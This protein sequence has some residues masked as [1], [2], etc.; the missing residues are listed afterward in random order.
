[1]KKT[2][3]LI[4]VLTIVGCSAIPTESPN[5]IQ[6]DKVT[7]SQ[8][9]TLAEQLLGYQFN[10]IDLDDGREHCESHI[11]KDGYSGYISFVSNSSGPLTMGHTNIEFSIFSFSSAYE[12]L[13]KHNFSALLLFFIGYSHPDEARS[14]ANWAKNYILDHYQDDFAIE[15]RWFGPVHITIYIYDANSSHGMLSALFVVDET[16]N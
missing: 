14:A 7:A 9:C 2:A 13:F 1:M 16:S 3:F 15:S 4:I 6:L 8:A 5:E 12:D 11:I 10:V